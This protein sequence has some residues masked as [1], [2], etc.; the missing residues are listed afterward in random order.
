MK[1]EREIADDLM[2]GHT[3]CTA[4]EFPNS[5]LGLAIATVATFTLD[6]SKDRRILVRVD[7]G[8]D[9]SIEAPLGDI[10][11][12]FRNVLNPENHMCW[13]NK[14]DVLSIPSMLNA[15]AGELGALSEAA[16]ALAESAK[17]WGDEED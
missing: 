14:A 17:G 5:P 6:I 15:L 16:R 10:L 8:D 4:P 13:F 9:V 7:L 2:M 1:T 12:N 3:Q 11:L